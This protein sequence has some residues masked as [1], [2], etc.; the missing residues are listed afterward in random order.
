MNANH[1][2][3]LEQL[4]ERS[5]LCWL[6]TVDS[7]GQPHVSPKEIFVFRPPNELLIAHI[8]SPGSVRNVRDQPMVCVSL[9]DVLVQKGLKCLGIAQVVEPADAD[10]AQSV[11]PLRPLVGDR[12]TILAVIRVQVRDVAPIWAPSYVF[13]PHDTT[14]AGQVAAAKQAYGL[15]ADRTARSMADKPLQGTVTD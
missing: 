8:A 7:T 14:E 11:Q 15:I 12:F 1:L 2:H 10:Y 6:A 3:A 9:V 5:V 13:Y 4:V